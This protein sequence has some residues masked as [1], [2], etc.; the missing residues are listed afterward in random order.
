MVRVKFFICSDSAAL[1]ARL[2]TVSAFHIMEQL[3]APAFPVAIPRVAVLALVSREE[4]D[5]NNVQL[6][7]QIVCGQ[8]H[9]FDGPVP[10]NFNQQL[11]AR[12]IID[13]QGLVLPAPGELRLLLMNA[14]DTIASWTVLVNHVGQAGAQLFFPAPPPPV[15]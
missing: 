3:N 11:S 13:M 10:V 7:L 8:Q 2:N 4:T 1:D 15:A 12:T 6:H 14:N 9:L 5:P